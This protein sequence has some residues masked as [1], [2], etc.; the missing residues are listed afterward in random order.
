MEAGFQLCDA[1]VMMRA[2]V[3]DDDPSVCRA[4]QTILSRQGFEAVLASDAHAGIQAFESSRFDVVIVDIFMS[5]MNGLEAIVEFRQRA[6]TVRIVAIFR[7]RDSM[8]PGLDFL[9]MAAE[10]GATS[11]LRKPFGPQQLLAAIKPCFDGT[12]PCDPSPGNPELR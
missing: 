3:I 12:F 6:P 9:G 11:C 1:P 2:L 7:F 10:L 4:I 8:G 5:A